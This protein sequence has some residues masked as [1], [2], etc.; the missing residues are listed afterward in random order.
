MD[1]SARDVQF[2]EK[3]WFRGKSFDGFGPFGP[4]LATPDEVGDPHRLDI[5]LKVNGITRQSSTTGRMTYQIDFI[6]YYLSHSMTLLPG[7]IIATGTPAGVGVFASPPRF[8][9]RGDR[10]EATIEKLGTLTNFVA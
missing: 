6:V 8:L 5:S 1:I 7:D 4:F 10:L 2:R 9:Q 3:Q